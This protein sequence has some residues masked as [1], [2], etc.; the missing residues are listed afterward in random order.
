M[1]CPAAI[2][3]VVDVPRLEAPPLDASPSRAASTTTLAPKTGTLANVLAVP[4][5]PITRAVPAPVNVSVLLAL[6]PEIVPVS[7]K[8]A[9]LAPPAPAPVV[10]R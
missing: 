9:P 2:C 7:R 6:P 1:S 8:P 5:R 4:S 10:N 3:R